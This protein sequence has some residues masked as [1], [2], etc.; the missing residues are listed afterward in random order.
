MTIAVLEKGEVMGEWIATIFAILLGF[1]LI[2]IVLFVLI[3]DALHGTKTGEAMDEK[4]A[5]LIGGKR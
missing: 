3:S 4:I 2:N 1:G 5:K